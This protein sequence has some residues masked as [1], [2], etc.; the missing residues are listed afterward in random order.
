M[1]HLVVPTRMYLVM[2]ANPSFH[3]WRCRTCGILLGV[4]RDGRLHLQ[5]RPQSIRLAE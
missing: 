4:E 3:Q 2:D 1:S 5:M